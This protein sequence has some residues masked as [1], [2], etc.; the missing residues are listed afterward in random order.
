MHHVQELGLTI[1]GFGASNDLHMQVVDD[2]ADA[3]HHVVCPFLP[4]LGRA[5]LLLLPIPS[6][7]PPASPS[8]K[9]HPHLCLAPLLNVNT[10]PILRAI[11]HALY[12]LKAWLDWAWVLSKEAACLGR[13]EFAVAHCA[14]VYGSLVQ[15]GLSTSTPVVLVLGAPGT[16]FPPA[17]GSC[18]PPPPPSRSPPPTP[19]SKH[20]CLAPLCNVSSRHDPPLIFRTVAYALWTLKAWLDWA[21]G[22]GIEERGKLGRWGCRIRSFICLR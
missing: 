14:G 5:P 7:S 12:T 21:W 8:S 18:T 6:R 11:A 1:R 20:L 10:P 17:T 3:R 13:A 22:M 4:Q 2:N 15:A 9:H 16:S 19:S